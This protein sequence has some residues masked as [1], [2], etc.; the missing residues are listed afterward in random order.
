[1][2]YAP[3]LPDLPHCLP[4]QDAYLLAVDIVGVG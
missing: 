1:M 3:D 4:R 2:I